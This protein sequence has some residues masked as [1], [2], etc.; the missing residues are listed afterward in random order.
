MGRGHLS[1]FLQLRLPFAF[2]CY[3]LLKINKVIRANEMY[4]SAL[5]E[6]LGSGHVLVLLLARY[7]RHFMISRSKTTGLDTIPSTVMGRKAARGRCIGINLYIAKL[8]VRGIAA[9]AIE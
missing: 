7:C 4:I 2:L 5:K 9:R 3:K 6:L 8:V 1:Q